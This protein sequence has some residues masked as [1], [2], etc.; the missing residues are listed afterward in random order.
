VCEQLTKLAALRDLG[1]LADDE[2]TAQ[3]VKLLG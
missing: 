2:F 3:K 1:I